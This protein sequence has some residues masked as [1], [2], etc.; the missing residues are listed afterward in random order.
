LE[1][2]GILNPKQGQ[3]ADCLDSKYKNKKKTIN[4]YFL[5]K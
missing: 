3:I 1:K 4:K 5:A 2:C